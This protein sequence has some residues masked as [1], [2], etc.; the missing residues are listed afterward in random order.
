[1]TAAALGAA[2]TE[3]LDV[4]ASL[5]DADARPQDADEWDADEVLAHVSL[6]TAATIAVA[7]DVAA[8]VD[9]T[10]EN[11]PASD[12]WT[13]RRLV[14]RAGGRPGLRQRIETQG[15][16]LGALVSVLGDPELD[17]PI[18]TLLLSHGA[19]LVDQPLPLRDLIAGLAEGELPGH[20]RQLLAL[21]PR[22]TGGQR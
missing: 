13:I 5:G 15:G 6:V 20:R 14:A 19:V 12:L 7:A 1:M 4:A 10:F 21:S 9:T 18:P 17:T 16:A 22:G 3:L 11:R 2:F 8:G